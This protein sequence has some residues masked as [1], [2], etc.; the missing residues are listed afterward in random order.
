[1]ILSDLRIMEDCSTTTQVRRANSSLG[2]STCSLTYDNI[3]SIGC[4]CAKEK[5]ADRCYGVGHTLIT[6]SS[7]LESW[8]ITLCFNA[9]EAGLRRR[10]GES[11]ILTHGNYSHVEWSVQMVFD[12]GL[13]EE[14]EDYLR[15]HMR[16]CSHT[17]LVGA[18]YTRVDSSTA[19]EAIEGCR[20]INSESRRIGR[21]WTRVCVDSGD[22]TLAMGS[23]SVDYCDW[24]IS[25]TFYYRSESSGIRTQHDYEVV[26]AADEIVAHSSSS[27]HYRS[28]LLGIGIVFTRTR[29]LD[30]RMVCAVTHGD[31]VD[32]RSDNYMALNTLYYV[33]SRG[34]S[35][36]LE[37][38]S[39]KLGVDDLVSVM[40]RDV[41]TLSTG[42]VTVLSSSL[43]RHFVSRGLSLFY[44]GLG[45][46]SSV[47][48]VDIRG[49]RGVVQRATVGAMEEC[50]YNCCEEGGVVD[51]GGARVERLD[52][53]AQLFV[54]L[55]SLHL[56]SCSSFHRVVIY[57]QGGLGTL[58]LSTYTRPLGEQHRKYR[59]RSE[60][61]KITF[62][63]YLNREMGTAYWC[64][65]RGVL[66]DRTTICAY[67]TH[68]RLDRGASLH[69]IWSGD[70]AEW[71][72]LFAVSIDKKSCS[73][74]NWETQG[75]LGEVGGYS[76]SGSGRE[77]FSCASGVV[78]R[79]RA[80]RR[81]GSTKWGVVGGRR[82]RSALITSGLCVREE[83]S[84]VDVVES[85]WG[86]GRL[87]CGI[88]VRGDILIHCSILQSGEMEQCVEMRQRGGCECGV[89]GN[90]CV[91]VGLDSGGQR[92]EGD[93]WCI[94]GVVCDGLV[95]WGMRGEC[96]GV[97]GFNGVYLMGWGVLLRYC[98]GDWR[99]KN[100]CGRNTNRISSRHVE[101]KGVR[102]RSFLKR[103]SEAASVQKASRSA[104]Q[105]NGNGFQLSSGTSV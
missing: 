60:S 104:H 101:L 22:E 54:D 69:I 90:T 42:C 46:T 74:I 85:V 70:W 105:I 44:S 41:I 103:G 49:R 64:I 24:V 72:T 18:L 102:K 2:R 8:S 81:L 66:D 23:A 31:L 73:V 63:T 10:I 99:L 94:L 62:Y 95:G 53:I 15:Q 27:G 50:R 84:G 80:G 35:V 86:I 55:C 82:L 52:H 56:M 57:R 4:Y 43:E 76:D 71:H 58:R 1:M 88:V 61:W 39:V 3:E 16:E 97:V 19:L 40:S 96:C 33:L 38:R 47:C 28:V 30:G 79:S 77:S 12:I 65:I 5:L 17:G 32:M 93:L 13:S 98:C 45:C 29:V 14:A 91:A 36:Y 68:L 7:D 78:V 89:G 92:E 26:S 51:R 48:R 6:L 9:D 67:R 83:G 87:V 75:R 100:V 11:V 20:Q 37:C 25:L 21:R 34:V 59:G